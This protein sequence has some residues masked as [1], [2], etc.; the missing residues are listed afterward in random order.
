MEGL[1]VLAG[2]SPTLLDTLQSPEWQELLYKTATYLQSVRARRSIQA[3][4][5]QSQLQNQELISREEELR[6]N[7]EELSVT[8]EEMRRTQKLL[9]ERAYWQNVLNDLAGLLFQNIASLP[10]FRSL[11]RIFVAQLAKHLEARAL[12]LVHWEGEKGQTLVSWASKKSPIALPETWTLPPDLI[13]TLSRQNKEIVV[14]ASEIGLSGEHVD[15]IVSPYLTP[16]RLEGLL[17]VIGS[18]AAW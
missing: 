16:K 12:A 18:E 15:C 14:P 9:E 17:L 11:S 8:Q 1:W 7:L 3:L 13:Q 2:D 4:L 5:E 10:V 6:Q